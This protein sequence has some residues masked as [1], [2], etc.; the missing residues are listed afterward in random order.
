MSV[1]HVDRRPRKMNPLALTLSAW[2]R[3][4][5]DRTELTRLD[6]RFVPVLRRQV[7]RLGPLS[8]ALLTPE[9]ETD[10][11]HSERTENATNRG[12]NNHG[13]VRTR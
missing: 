9:T 12:A 1:V 2:C 8:L 4:R 5:R 13:C 11:P 6:F 7:E 3:E 10:K